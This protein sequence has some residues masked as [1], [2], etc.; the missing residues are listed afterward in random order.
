MDDLDLVGSLEA[1]EEDMD[2]DGVEAEEEE[3]MEAAEE[4]DVEDVG[5][6]IGKRNERLARIIP[7]LEKR[8]DID[9]KSCISAKKG[10][11]SG[12]PET[13]QDKD[14]KKTDEVRVVSTVNGGVMP[15]YVCGKLFA[16]MPN[17]CKFCYAHKRVLDT[18]A[19]TWQ[20]K[21][22]KNNQKKEG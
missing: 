20:P 15:C 3:D 9:A 19:K 10:G 16:I 1:P 8:S 13:Q 17:N 14:K 6:F 11:N 22:T 4:E 21:R 18:L 12:K 2:E 5:S 7:Q